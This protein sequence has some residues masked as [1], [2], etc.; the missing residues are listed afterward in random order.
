MTCNPLR[1]LGAITRSRSLL[2]DVNFFA[3]HPGTRFLLD[4]PQ[5]GFFVSRTNKKMNEFFIGWCDQ[6]SL[7]PGPP[8]PSGTVQVMM[9]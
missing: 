6:L 7:Y 5:N 3:D 4:M 9:P 8:P 2:I 1:D